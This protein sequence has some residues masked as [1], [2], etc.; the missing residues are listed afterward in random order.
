MKDDGKGEL[1]NCIDDDDDKASGASSVP[2]ENAI[3]L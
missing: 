3:E 1:G 2:N